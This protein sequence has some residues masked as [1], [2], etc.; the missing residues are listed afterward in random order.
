MNLK[1]SISTNPEAFI[2]LCKAHEVKEMYAFGSSVREDFREDASDFDFIVELKT[3]DPI[4]RGDFILA[5]W[6][7][8]EAFFQRPVDLLTPGAIKNP[9]LKKNIQASKILIYDGKGLK[10]S[11]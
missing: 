2:S 3:Q 6:E 8:L 9:V 7:G 10:V 5:L 4:R 11:Y 1:E